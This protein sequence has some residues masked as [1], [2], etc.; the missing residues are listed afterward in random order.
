VWWEN[1]EQACDDMSYHCACNTTHLYV[2]PT[3]VLLDSESAECPICAV[4]VLVEEDTDN[5]KHVQIFDG[6]L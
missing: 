3:V 4:Y 5:K 2:L 1:R 6:E